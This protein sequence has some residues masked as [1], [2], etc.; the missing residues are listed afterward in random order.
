MSNFLNY[1]N[2]LRQYV[3]ALSPEQAQ[4][5]VNEAW[6]DIR[7]SDDEWSFLHQTEYWIA[8]AVIT[9]TTGVSVTQFDADVTV[10]ADQ[11]VNVAGLNNPALTQ[12]QI[13]FSPS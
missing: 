2:R 11:L 1:S 7:D 12:R 3:Q 5:Y 9:L 6:R 4:D 13:R 10:A 8:P